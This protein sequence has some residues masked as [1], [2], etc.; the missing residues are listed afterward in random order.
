MKFRCHLKT[1]KIQILI[2]KRI[3]KG[4][5]IKRANLFVNIID[6]ADAIKKNDCTFWHPQ[7][8]NSPLRT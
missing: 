6:M 5:K 8:H 1:F 4:L 2:T 7:K 3:R